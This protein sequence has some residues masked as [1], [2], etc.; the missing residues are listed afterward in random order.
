M[1]D[2]L[3]FVLRVYGAI[4]TILYACPGGPYLFRFLE[5]YRIASVL[6]DFKL[7]YD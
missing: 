4:P 5:R 1:K 2:F 6:G 7:G 3:I